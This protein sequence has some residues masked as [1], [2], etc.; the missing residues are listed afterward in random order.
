LKNSTP[1]GTLDEDGF[2]VFEEVFE[3]TEVGPYQFFF[4]RLFG[5]MAMRG[6]VSW[7]IV[8]EW[9]G[10]ARYVD[11]EWEMVLGEYT[12]ADRRFLEMLDQME[13]KGKELEESGR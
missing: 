9:R 4:V 6:L 7:D 10:K 1:I 12:I 2:R 11:R 5:E 3:K 13:L 8:R